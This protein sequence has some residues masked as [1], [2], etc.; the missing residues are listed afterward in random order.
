MFP[1]FPVIPVALCW[2]L[3]IWRSWYLFGS[4]QMGSG[5]QPV[6]EP[7]WDFQWH[8]RGLT[9]GV[10]GQAA[11]CPGLQGQ[12]WALGSLRASA[13][14]SGGIQMYLAP[15]R[16]LW[17][18][19]LSQCCKSIFCHLGAITLTCTPLLLWRFLLWEYL[20]KLIFPKGADHQ[21][22][23]VLPSCWCDSW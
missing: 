9:A 6:Q 10:L 20:F 16:L 22:T 5:T 15:H 19:C 18:A 13:R 8:S 2:H 23:P 4:A 7:G 17:G 12:V 11:W 21:K 3:D 14:V 1:W